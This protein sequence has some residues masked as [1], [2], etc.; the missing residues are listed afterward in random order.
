MTPEIQPIDLNDY[1]RAGEGANGESYNHK[2][3]PDIMVKIYSISTDP[4]LVKT[5]LEA[6]RKVYAAG[7]PSPEPGTLVVDGQGRL[8]LRFRRLV[9]KVSYARAVGNHPEEVEKYARMFADMCRKLHSTHIAPGQFPSVKDQYLGMLSEN[10]FWT[11]RQKAVIEDIIRSTPDTDTALHG[12]LQNGNLLLCGGESYFIDLGEF[13]TGH[14]Y[15]DLGMTVICGVYNDPAFTEEFFHMTNETARKF[16]DFFVDQ[17]FEG[18]YTG[19]E[20]SE[21]LMPYAI[22]KSLLIERNSKARCDRF[23]RYFN[24]RYGSL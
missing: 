1:I 7:I 2:S 17:Y 19:D 11:D 9:D 20:A 3:D 14:P 21:M 10:P 22:V 16:W 24:E 12:D 5:E 18:R 15:F 4:E 23:H 6:A 13:A 8:G